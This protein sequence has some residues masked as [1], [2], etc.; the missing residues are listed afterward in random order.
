MSKA[1]YILCAITS[2]TCALLLLR[3]YR[4]SRHRLLFWSALCFAV[5]GLNNTVMVLDFIVISSVDLTILRHLTAHLAL[6]VL[7]FGL[8]WTSR[9]ES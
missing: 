5:L 8:V 1:V 3:G 2:V 9:S 6:W 4:A 7:L